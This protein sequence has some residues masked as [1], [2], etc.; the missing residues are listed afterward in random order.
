M[1]LDH[2]LSGG[3]ELTQLAKY[4]VR[5]LARQD[6]MLSLTKFHRPRIPVSY[7]LDDSARRRADRFMGYT[8]TMMPLL[9]ELSALAEDVKALE[10]VTASSQIDPACMP[11]F[12]P[13]EL[14]DRAAQLQSDLES[15]HPTL[16]PTLSFQSSRKFLMHATAYRSAGLLYL[17]RLFH[18]PGSS[19]QAD[20]TALVMA[21]EIM[22]H[23]TSNVEDLKMSL[24]P[25]FLA[26]CEATSEEDR[27]TAAQILDSICRGRRTITAMRTKSFIVNRVWHA[28]DSG[29]DWNWMSLS[30]RY[31]D[32]LLPI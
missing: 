11:P 19:V 6:M 24:W 21:Y 23:T 30:L 12:G 27:L 5:A 22:V 20:Q 16:D 31:P 1:M 9:A 25:V 32:E 2:R 18:P 29:L 8:A 17:Y 14:L 4:F 15:W 28:R 3:S 26:A 10:S 13:D 7:W